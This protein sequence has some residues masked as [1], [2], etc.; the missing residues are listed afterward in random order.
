MKSCGFATKSLL[1]LQFFD[2]QMVWPTLQIEREINL[3]LVRN[4]EYSES[5]IKFVK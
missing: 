1:A 4:P 5:F 3:N 2:Y